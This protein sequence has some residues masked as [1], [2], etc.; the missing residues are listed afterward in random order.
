VFSPK[1][2]EKYS[3]IKFL[4]KPSSSFYVDGRTDRQTDTRSESH[5]RFSQFCK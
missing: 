2:L 3:N 1:I 5:S 4:R